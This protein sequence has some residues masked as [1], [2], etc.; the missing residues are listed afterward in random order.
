M[1]IAPTIGR[2]VHYHL[3][4][5]GKIVPAIVVDIRS[6]DHID[7]FLMC[8]SQAATKYGHTWFERSVRHG[9]ENGQW[10]W[11]SIEVVPA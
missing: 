5:T 8:S 10:E 3:I 2:I 9:H 7:L 6:E 1:G 4:D 11:P